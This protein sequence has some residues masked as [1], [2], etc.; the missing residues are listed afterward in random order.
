MSHQDEELEQ[1]GETGIYTG[2]VKVPAW[3]KLSYLII[4]IWGIVWLFLYWNGASG[5]I[6]RGHWDELEK[7]A[8]TQFPIENANEPIKK[9][10]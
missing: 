5:W 1:Y 6:D 9:T 8:N 10:N 2:D 7:A 4:P 3:L